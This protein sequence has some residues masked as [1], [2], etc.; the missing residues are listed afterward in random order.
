MRSPSHCSIGTSRKTKTRGDDMKLTAEARTEML[1]MAEGSGQ[2]TAAEVVDRAR[3]KNSPLHDY[4]EWDDK[5]AGNACRIEQARVLIRTVKVEYW[6][7]TRV[8][9]TVAFARDPNKPRSEA[10]YASVI[11][12]KKVDMRSVMRDEIERILELF[13]RAIDIATAKHK[14]L[15]A[16]LADAMK[17]Q[18]VGLES[19]L[20]T[21]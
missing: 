17:A 9:K 4:F 6:F 13:A 1:N 2:I 5:K 18:R 16:G 21:L 15:P 7:E 10:G 14:E 3:N 12:M 11:K 20:G 19:I 8:V